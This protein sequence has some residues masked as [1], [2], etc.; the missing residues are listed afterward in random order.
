MAQIAPSAPRVK[1]EWSISSVA[2][3]T[4]PRSPQVTFVSYMAMI[5]PTLCLIPMMCLM[6]SSC[7]NSSEEISFCGMTL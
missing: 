4:M 5:P 1:Q 6:S 2:A 7:E 3:N